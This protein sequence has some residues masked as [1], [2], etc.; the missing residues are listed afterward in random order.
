MTTT[1]RGY[2]LVWMLLALVGVAVRVAYVNR[3]AYLDE[4]ATFLDYARLPYAEIIRTYFDPNNHV[5]YSVQ[6][7]ASYRL[8]GFDLW[9]LRLP[10]LLAGIL[11]PLLAYAVARRLYDDDV[12]LLTLGLTAVSAPLIEYSISGRG[13]AFVTVCALGVLGLGD[14]LL[15]SARGRGV[16]VF[17]WL[18]VGVLAALGFYAVPTMLYPLGGVALWLLV[19][20]WQT[21]PRRV[22]GLLGGL[23]VGALLTIA[24][25]SPII[26]EYGLSA[27]TSNRHIV[28]LR[29]DDLLPR[30]LTEPRTLLDFIGLGWPRVVRYALV[31][32]LLVAVVRHWTLA[33]ERFPLWLAFVVW[34]VVLIGVQ[35][36]IP[37]TRIWNLIVPF[38]LMW[39]SAGMVGLL[40][41]VWKHPSA[42]VWGLI[43]VGW[44]VGVIVQGIP[45]SYAIS[46]GAHD[47][48]AVAE[49]VQN[50]L[51]DDAQ[52]L[53]VAGWVHP[54]WY[55]YEWLGLDRDGLYLNGDFDTLQAD[56]GVLY[57]LALTDDRYLD[58]RTREAFGMVFDEADL[59]AH[60]VYTEWTLYTIEQGTQP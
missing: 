13:Y 49:T 27:L 40:R 34:L 21:E 15:Q 19:T 60:T 36:V 44:L 37:P 6:M 11:V 16:T 58:N 46:S 30:L 50:D 38:V 47:A 51:A 53:F 56:D 33:R 20:G 43:S 29:Y 26:R 2:R 59:T 31:V 8:F 24:F 39:V 48:Q 9:A 23:T 25:Y 41:L 54:L 55:Y 42:W 1:K 57:L 22:V 32:P 5:F 10:A 12:A 18:G 35:R 52:V 7:H 3:P 4:S 45:N 28:P 14:W 17:G